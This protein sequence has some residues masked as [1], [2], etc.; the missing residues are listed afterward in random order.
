M[1]SVNIAFLDEIMESLIGGADDDEAQDYF[2][3]YDFNCDNDYRMIIDRFILPNYQSKSE[4][5]KSK[6]KET[7]RFSL[8]KKGF[9]FEIRFDALLPP[10]DAPSDPRDF[11]LWIWEELFG[12]EPYLIEDLSDY[13]EV[14]D[15]EEPLYLDMKQ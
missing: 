4:R 5:M 12:S 10:F 15:P 7:L 11:Y 1:K 9:P 2:M 13:T 8:S 14:D 6:I 3:N